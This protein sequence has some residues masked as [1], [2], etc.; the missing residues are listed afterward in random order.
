MVPMATLVAAAAA[1]VPIQRTS[2]GFTKESALAPRELN[3]ADWDRVEATSRKMQAE[4]RIFAATHVLR[5]VVT[6]QAVQQMQAEGFKCG[7]EML[8]LGQLA[9][10]RIHPVVTCIMQSR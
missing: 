1:A 6:A 9:Q 10:P 3:G 5:G 7:I 4:S 2:D 8:D